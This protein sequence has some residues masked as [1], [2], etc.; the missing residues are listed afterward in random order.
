MHT[1]IHVVC[2]EIFAFK[3][4]PNNCEFGNRRKHAS[5]YIVGIRDRV[6]PFVFYNNPIRRVQVSWSGLNNSFLSGRSWSRKSTVTAWIPLSLPGC[7]S[8]DGPG[9]RVLSI[10]S[11]VVHGYVGNTAAT[12]PLQVSLGSI[13]GKP[14]AH[15]YLS[16]CTQLL[17]YEVEALNSINFCNPR[18]LSGFVARHPSSPS[19]KATPLKMQKKW[20][21][22]KYRSFHW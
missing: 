21:N 14:T 9:G 6:F 8:M 13:V 5:W 16:K 15:V 7:P 2:Q 10:Q 1:N 4:K 19:S 12:F 17:G 3:L 11:H 18:S 20:R 22:A